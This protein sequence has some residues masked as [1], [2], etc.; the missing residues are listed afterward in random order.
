MAR[1]TD[2]ENENVQREAH[3][4][5]S[6]RNDGRQDVYPAS[7]GERLSRAND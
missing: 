4:S 5:R 1:D 3:C 2:D 7:V 6:W